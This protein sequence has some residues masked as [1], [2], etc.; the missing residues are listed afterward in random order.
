MKYLLIILL[1]ST[2]IAKGQMV[3][4]AAKFYTPTKGANYRY[5]GWVNT[6]TPSD[7]TIRGLNKDGSS[8][9]GLNVSNTTPTGNQYYVYYHPSF[10]GSIGVIYVNYFPST[11]AFTINTVT[12]NG[13]NYERIISNNPLNTITTFSFQ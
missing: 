13:I 5:W 1:F 6:K 12:F 8:I 10:L 3:L 7:A 4:N 2:T 9:L 11:M